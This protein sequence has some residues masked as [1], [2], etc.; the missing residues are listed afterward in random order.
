VKVSKKSL[1]TRVDADTQAALKRIAATEGISINQ[2]VE[3]ILVGHLSKRQQGKSGADWEGGL[4]DLEQWIADQLQR[5]NRQLEAVEKRFEKSLAALRVMVDAS[6]EMRD[7]A[8]MD[9][10][11]RM[12]AGTLRQMGIG[13]SSANGVRQ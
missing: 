9:E 13:T 4:R 10:Y 3:R 6:V 1:G 2:L 8:R 5:Q 11:R 7:P 12:V